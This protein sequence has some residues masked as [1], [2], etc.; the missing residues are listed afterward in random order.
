MQ[1]TPHTIQQSTATFTTEATTTIGSASASPTI[2]AT[3]TSIDEPTTITQP[4]ST[5]TME[6][7]TDGATIAT[8]KPPGSRSSTDIAG[9]GAVGDNHI[10][11]NFAGP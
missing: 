10:S 5:I 4:N 3:T 8:H 11:H 9:G 1:L 2:M 6:T 7:A